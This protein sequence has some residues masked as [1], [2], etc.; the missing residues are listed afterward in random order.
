[1]SSASK[2]SDQSFDGFKSILIMEIHVTFSII[3]ACIPFLTPVMNSLQTGILSSDLR[4][5][6]GRQTA[7]GYRYNYPLGS[8]GKGSSGL[9]S[10][11][12][13]HASQAWAKSRNPSNNVTITTG[14]QDGDLIDENQ[15]GRNGSE[16]R[17]IIKQT[18]T[19]VQFQNE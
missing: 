13:S 6:P 5:L 17:M 9:Y 1:L 19:T 12:G 8:I 3:T 2:S 18:T 10:S 11:R 14:T 4:S 7:Q 15:N 16:D